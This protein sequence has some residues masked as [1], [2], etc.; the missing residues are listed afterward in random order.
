MEYIVVANPLNDRE[1][2][3]LEG[4]LSRVSLIQRNSERVSWLMVL[5]EETVRGARVMSSLAVVSYGCTIIASRE[6]LPSLR[7]EVPE[8]KTLDFPPS[9]AYEVGSVMIPDDE[10][11]SFLKEFYRQSKLNW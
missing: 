10:R 7:L 5:T 2:T 8:E 4:L 3:T 11:F 6:S 9:C 1:N